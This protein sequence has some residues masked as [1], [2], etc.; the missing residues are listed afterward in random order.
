MANDPGSNEP[1]ETGRQM[2]GQHGRPG[3]L[4]PSARQHQ[5][6]WGTWTKIR[7][8]YIFSPHKSICYTEDSGFSNIDMNKLE[9]LQ[10]ANFLSQI[11]AYLEN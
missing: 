1:E 11:S 10:T 7:L 5:K 2:D 6:G 9:I 8:A 4:E 3:Y